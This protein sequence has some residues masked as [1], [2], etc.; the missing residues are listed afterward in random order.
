MGNIPTSE[1][2]GPNEV[3]SRLYLG[4]TKVASLLSFSGVTGLIISVQ[5]MIPC[6]KQ[7]TFH[8]CFCLMYMYKIMIVND[9]SFLSMQCFL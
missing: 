2:L 7:E 6:I 8:L 9:P 3:V 1:G 5:F 4:Q